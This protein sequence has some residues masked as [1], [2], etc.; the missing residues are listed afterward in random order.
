MWYFHP[1]GCEIGCPEISETQEGCEKPSEP[2]LIWGKDDAFLQYEEE[3][4]ALSFCHNSVT[5][6]VLPVETACPIYSF[7][8][9]TW[10]ATAIFCCVQTFTFYILSSNISTCISLFWVVWDFV[11]KCI[12]WLVQKWCRT[13][14]VEIPSSTLGVIR[15][16]LPWKMPVA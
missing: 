10:N 5:S 3:G 4:M 11:Q 14:M 9:Q 16:K 7:G 2:T 15:G 12:L 8:Y 13:V 6:S 1:W